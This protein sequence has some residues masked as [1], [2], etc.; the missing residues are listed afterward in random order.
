[1]IQMIFQN[2]GASL[3]PA[4]G[5]GTQISRAVRR[6]NPSLSAS[7]RAAHVD[8]L[9]QA[10]GL[11]PDC[12]ARLP[13]EVSGGQAQRAAISLAFVTRPRVVIA[14]EP[15]S[16]LDPSIQAAVMNMLVSMTRGR[17]TAMIL[18]SHDLGLVRH[19]ADRTAVL[20]EGRL[21]EIGETDQIFRHPSHPYSQGLIAEASRA[22]ADL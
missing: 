6:A 2:A 8:A 7:E 19:V 12:K 13:Q 11:E 21:V 16:A 9:L 1:M 14:D 20:Y 5:I 4:L 22:Q 3:N 15:T 10:A 17:G 18:I